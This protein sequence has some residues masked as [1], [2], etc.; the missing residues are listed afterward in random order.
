M[1]K[2]KFEVSKAI[3]GKYQVINTHLPKLESRIGLVDF[4]TISLD[5][6]ERLVKAGTRYLRKI[7]KAKKI[8]KKDIDL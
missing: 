2:L 3:E 1:A 4:R 6:A 5:Q 7:E 8:V